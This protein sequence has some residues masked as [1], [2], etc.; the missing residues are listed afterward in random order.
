[1]DK[2][3]TV[4]D[5]VPFVEIRA[6]FAPDVNVQHAVRE[7]V[8]EFMRMTRAAVDEVYTDVPCHETE[9]VVDMQQCRQLVQVERVY[10][11][12]PMCG[13]SGRWDR[14]WQVLPDSEVHQYGWWVDDV[15]GPNATLWLGTPFPAKQ[16]LCI[17]YSWA[18]ERDACAI[19]MWVYQDY[20]D[21]IAAGAAAY[22]HTNANVDGASVSF[23]ARMREEF[24]RGVVT[25]KT[26]KVSQ[27]RTR[28]LKMGNSTFFWG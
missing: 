14:T 6:P 17:R 20:A 2:T 18:I 11:A 27:Y 13:P 22:L 10:Q 16:R 3:C 19:P 5:F 7:T 26:R 24:V 21:I 12:P 1:M 15:G 4:A 9:I 28:R 8:I 25:A 23:G